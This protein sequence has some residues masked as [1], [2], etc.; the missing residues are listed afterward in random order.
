VLLT[1]KSQLADA[2]RVDFFGDLLA[3]LFT[4]AGSRRGAGRAERIVGILS[5]L[6]ILLLLGFVWLAYSGF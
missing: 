4:P 3:G 2:S 1:I 6:G 5:V